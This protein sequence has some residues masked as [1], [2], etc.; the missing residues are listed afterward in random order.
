MLQTR[1]S[2]NQVSRTNRTNTNV[3]FSTI[4][5]SKQTNASCSPGHHPADS[6]LKLSYTDKTSQ[7]SEGKECSSIFFLSFS[8]TTGPKKKNLSAATIFRQ[9]WGLILLFELLEVLNARGDSLRALSS[10]CK[11]KKQ[12]CLSHQQPPAV[13]ASP[14]HTKGKQ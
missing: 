1:L 7:Y 9:T 8:H 5:S 4:Q 3:Q 13:V 12:Q 11:T 6:Y 14:T 2:N 10:R